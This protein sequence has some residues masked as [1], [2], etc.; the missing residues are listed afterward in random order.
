MKR[1]SARPLVKPVL[2][3]PVSSGFGAR[4]DPFTRRVA[5]HSGTDFPGPYNTPVH[6]TAAG[7]VSRAGRYSAYGR[8]VEIDHGFGFKTR[9]G[10]LNQIKVDVGDKVKFRQRSV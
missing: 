10:H 3:L 2:G 1:W 6:A 8:L 9:Y 4:L 5:F 7:T